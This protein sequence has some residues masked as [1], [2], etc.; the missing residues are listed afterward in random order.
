MMKNYTL[1][2]MTVAALLTGCGDS[3]TPDQPTASPYRPETEQSVMDKIKVVD[4][5]QAPGQFVGHVEG[6]SVAEAC[7]S[8]EATV[9][10]GRWV[11]L[12]S[13][14]GYI[15]VMFDHS[16][17]DNPQDYD[18]AI[19]G[20]S[21]D[22]SN[23]PGTV[24][25]S[26][27]ENLNGLPDDTWLELRGSDYD[28]PTTLH[29][30]TVTYYC[31]QEGSPVAWTDSEGHEGTIDMGAF[32]SYISAY[33]Y[34]FTG[35]RLEARTVHEDRL[36]KN[37]PFAWG[38]VDNMGSD[39]LPGDNHDAGANYNRFRIEDAVDDNGRPVKLE[40]VDFIK[41]QCAVLSQSGP[42]GEVSTEVLGFKDL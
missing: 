12:G 1:I 13:F 30:Y 10:E 36:W 15:V 6:T 38:Y 22:S 26:Q 32:P 19:A 17:K 37:L 40:Y 2:I 34:S 31:A 20:N 3:D 11:S 39:R 24:W 27:D 8:A 35:T 7:L 5:R 9:N 41:V 28:E 25:V 21:F 16:V 4:I 23:E 18:F 42:L 33:T 29:S 14:G